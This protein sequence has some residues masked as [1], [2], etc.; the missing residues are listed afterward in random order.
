MRTD[1]KTPKSAIPLFRNGEGSWKVI[2]NPH[3]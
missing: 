2:R 3:L 1:S